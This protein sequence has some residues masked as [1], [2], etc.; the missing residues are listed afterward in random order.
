[1]DGAEWEIIISSES[2]QFTLRKWN[3]SGDFENY[4]PFSDNIAKLVAVI[5]LLSAFYGEGR[6][7]VL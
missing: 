5:K 4:A 1:M 3:P 2:G 7:G 6:I